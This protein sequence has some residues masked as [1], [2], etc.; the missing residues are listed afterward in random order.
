MMAQ[1]LTFEAEEG[2][3][4][5]MSG[6]DLGRAVVKPEV[7]KID[8]VIEGEEPE[9]SSEGSPVDS[10]CQALVVGRVPWPITRSGRTRQWSVTRIAPE[11][12]L[13][14]PARYGMVLL[15]LGT[16]FMVIGY[17]NN[18]V[19][20]MKFLGLAMVILGILCVGSALGKSFSL[21]FEARVR[22]YS[23]L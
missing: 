8:G 16:L 15:Y 11:K 23:D 14:V 4:A 7:M 12:A 13:S 19:S 20:F 21:M 22:N 5:P 1:V 17:H 6:D 10:D 3:E 18:W 2:M 9:D